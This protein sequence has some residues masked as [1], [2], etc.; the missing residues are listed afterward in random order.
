MGIFDGL[1]KASKELYLARGDSAVHDLVWL[2]PVTSIPDGA[3]LTVRS[4]EV[5]VF[6]RE[7][8]FH[9][10]LQAG[11]YELNTDNVPFL[12]QLL[13]NHLTGGNDFICE[14][15]FVRRSEFIHE[16]TAQS[17]G[18]YTDLESRHVV[19]LM[20][21]AR[22]GVSVDDPLALI[23]MLG[24]QS[25]D[26]TKTIA[27]F[28]S[29]RIRSLL[30][31]VVGQLFAERSAL[32]VVS[33]SFN[34]EIGQLIHDRAKDEF[35][36][37][38][39]SF[40][41]FLGLELLLDPDSERALKEFGRQKAQ[42]AIEREGAELAGGY[43][44]YQLAQG[45]R[46]ALEGIGT[47]AASSGTG[48]LLGLS[49]GGLSGNVPP[50][51]NTAGAYRNAMLRAGA[52]RTSPAL[53]AAISQRRP[54]RWYLR[55][56]SGDAGPYSARQVVLR[57]LSEGLS[58]DNSEVRAES[59]PAWFMAETEDTLRREFERRAPTGSSIA[60][61]KDQDAIALFERMFS[62][63]AQDLVFTSD[64]LELLVPLARTAGIAASDSAARDAIVR[65]AKA[66]GCTIKDAEVSSPVANV[67][68]KAPTGRSSTS[69]E[70][71]PANTPSSTKTQSQDVDSEP[72][73]PPPPQSEPP[74]P[75]PPS[76][77]RFSYYDGEVKQKGLSAS[78][79]A[80]LITAN[81]TGY[82]VV[83]N[84]ALGKWTPAT[85]LEVICAQLDK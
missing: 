41:R 9:G 37:Q 66:Y 26:S 13:T 85:E 80:K 16:V 17:L 62:V 54:S 56:E 25:A 12:S 74:P 28:L 53:G 52:S 58:A 34:E 44:N 39:L 32:S 5:V 21:R 84:P 79:V 11:S 76:T 50:P 65:R 31:A 30:A 82:H 60:K 4:D 63:A 69:P 23:T 7:G 2:H 22:F 73:P 47:G 75:A 29:T 42:L 18:T 70:A 10:A 71:M 35:A 3:K 38:G 48:P 8:R 49:L 72:P 6:F 27:T 78:Q 36:E 68:S 43:A 40:T 61:R 33:N 15:F 59:D 45:Q 67:G 81:P 24:G 77:V 1:L 64:E 83:Y 55:L 19:T 14:L 20:F 51:S 46:A 57:A